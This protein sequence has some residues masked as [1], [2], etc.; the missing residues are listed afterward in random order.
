MRFA[1]AGLK[2][3]YR[4]RYLSS[5]PEPGMIMPQNRGF[6]LASRPQGAPVAENFRL[7]EMEMP[8]P[9]E[10]QVLVKHHYLSLDPYMRGRMND[11]KSYTAPQKIDEIM[12]G[13]TV[14]EVIASKH[15][16]FAPGDRVAGMGG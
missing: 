7:I 8:E 12:I 11:V 3:S 9:G 10:G 1:L 13:G 6:V 16:N 2:K 14:G 4:N 15:P 5:S